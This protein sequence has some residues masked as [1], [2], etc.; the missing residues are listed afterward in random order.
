MLVSVLVMLIIVG[1][2]SCSVAR[3][4]EEVAD[5]VE[6]LKVILFVEVAVVFGFPEA[7]RA[8]VQTRLSFLE[9]N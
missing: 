3:D 5:D 9:A 1:G 6:V 4:A 2:N 8:H 7:T